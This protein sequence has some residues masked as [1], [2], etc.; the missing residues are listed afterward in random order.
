[1]SNLLS[2]RGGAA[3]HRF[4]WSDTDE[5]SHDLANYNS[6]PS[7]TGHDTSYDTSPRA[8]YHPDFNDGVESYTGPVGSFAPNG[9]GLFD[10]TGNVFEW[11]HD[12]ADN[13]G[14]KY[15]TEAPATDPRGPV[16]GTFRVL[17]GGSWH[18]D[19]GWAR[20][21]AR[22][23]CNGGGKTAFPFLG[24]RSVLPAAQ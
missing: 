9:Y 21:S 5:I 2:A 1:M 20:A 23:I 4:S 14:I 22:T 15:Y 7:T 24:F 17:R 11:V 12:W 16:T 10:L 3:G 18:A 8:G 19:P 6:V 13:S